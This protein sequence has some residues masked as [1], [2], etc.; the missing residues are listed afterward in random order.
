MSDPGLIAAKLAAATT[1]I[2]N[3]VNDLTVTYMGITVKV[4]DHVTPDE[5]SALAVDVVNA[6]DDTEASW[7]AAHPVTPKGP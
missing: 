2:Q 7:A 4:G 6:V 1:A 3:Y 5:V